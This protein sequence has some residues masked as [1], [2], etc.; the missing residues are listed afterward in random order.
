MHSLVDYAWIGEML[1]C[2][3]HNT[4]DYLWIGKK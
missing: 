2:A 3:M 4:I 1:I